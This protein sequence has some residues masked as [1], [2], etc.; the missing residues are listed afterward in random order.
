MSKLNKLKYVL[1]D[2]NRKN[3][4]QIIVESLHAGFI[5]K[6]IPIFYFYNLLY[7]K[8]SNDYTNFVGMKKR[9]NILKYFYTPHREEFTNKIKFN[10]ILTS[11]N[12]PTPKIL[13]HSKNH[14]I[15]YKSEELNIN[16]EKEFGDFLE[17]VT[18]I[19]ST[20]SIFIKP[21]DGSGGSHAFRFDQDNFDQ[22]DIN[23]LF[24]LMTKSDF[25]FQETIIQN[26]IIQKI[27]PNSINTLRIY[28]Y[29]NRETQETEVILALLR[30]GS[31]GSVVDNE[32]MFIAIDINNQ[33]KLK[34]NAKSFLHNGGDSFEEHPDTGF[35]FNGFEIPFQDE[36]YKILEKAAPLLPKD[37]IGWDVALSADGPTIIEANDRP[38]VLMTQI[39]SGGFKGHP[40]FR[41]LLKE[42]I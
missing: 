15:K 38:H 23:N 34:G 10:N 2:Q 4:L 31:K 29:L 11:H 40:Q 6:E 14:K 5:E 30:V 7:K 39:M 20:R 1:K 37:F 12:I 9:N 32:S 22:N 27:Y 42:Y 16:N 8:D 41:K 24:T 19:S 36:I 3:M 18:K 33:W 35:T 28:T 13:A 21:L 17:K 26:S 25:I